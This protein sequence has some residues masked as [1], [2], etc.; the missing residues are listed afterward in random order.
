MKI[1]YWTSIGFYALVKIIFPIIY[2]IAIYKYKRYGLP[3]RSRK[4]NNNLA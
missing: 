2:N 3:I 4:I 1:F